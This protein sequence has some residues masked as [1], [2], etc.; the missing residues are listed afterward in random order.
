[1]TPTRTRALTES[2]EHLMALVTQGDTRAFEAIYDRHHHQAYA[3][4]RRI[5]GGTGGAEEATQDAFLALWRGASKFDAERGRLAPWL[6]ALV[7]HRSI[8]WL[9]RGAPH[10][11]V[12]NL[13]EGAAERI[14]APERTEEQVFAI[15]E[16]ERA[17]RLVAELPPEQR[18]VIDLAYFAG[19]SQ[20][21]IA[22]RVGVPLGTVKGRARLGL[23]KLRQAAERESSLLSAA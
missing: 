7:R 10:T 8:D 13:V 6:F 11:R 21:E 9:R 12:Q 5:T 18:A 3:L 15:Q 20:R 2:D 23:D 22:A 17:R 14:E 4:A 16:S 1:M 19:Y